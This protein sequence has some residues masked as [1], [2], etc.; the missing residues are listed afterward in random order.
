LIEIL[1][2]ELVVGIAVVADDYISVIILFDDLGYLL[3][4]VSA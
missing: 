1:A 2:D 4:I 3:D